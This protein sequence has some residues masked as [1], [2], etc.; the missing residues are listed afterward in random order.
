MFKKLCYKNQYKIRMIYYFLKR[1]F[2]LFLYSI[3]M[4]RKRRVK[5]YNKDFIRKK[6]TIMVYCAYYGDYSIKKF[7]RYIK[8]VNTR[9]LDYASKILLLLESRLDIIL[10]RLNLFK[11][12]RE[13]RSSVKNSKIMVNS[14]TIKKL[15]YQLYINDVIDIKRKYKKFLIKRLKE[16][17]RKKEVIFNYPK[18]L[19][20]SYRILKCI[21]IL[22]PKKKKFRLYENWICLF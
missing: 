3:S 8:R 16:K 11:N 17:L 14:K 10:C 22:Y 18:Y 4:A 9:R 5:H 21:F 12:P 7:K 1:Y 2:N 20:I 19:E 15:N 6:R 13:S